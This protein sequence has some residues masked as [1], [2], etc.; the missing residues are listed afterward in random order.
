MVLLDLSTFLGRMHPL[1]VHLP[2]GFLLIAGIFHLASYF[3]KYDNL[4]KATEL[5]LLLGT[6]SGIA[7]CVLGWLLSHT[8]DYSYQLLENHKLSGIGLTALS[9]I[10]YIL[11]S[12]KGKSIIVVPKKA[13]SAAFLSIIVLMSYAGHQ[14]ANLTHGTEYLTLA[15][16]TETKREI[17]EK[18]EDVLV[19]EDLVQPI[20]DKKCTQCHQ[21]SKRKGELVLSSYDDIMKGGK[22][23]SIL[24]LGKI[25]E[26]E[27]IRRVTLER[28]HED[29]MPSDGKT[30]L[31]KNELAI[32]KWWITNDVVNKDVSFLSL[33]SH[34]EVL[35]N[36]EVYLG[37][38]KATSGN[39]ANM[40]TYNPN[41]PVISDIKLL[42]EIE[43][44]GFTYRIMNH[45]PLMLDIAIDRN[46]L[47]PKIEVKALLPL[48]KHIIWLNLSNAAVTD[49]DLEEIGQFENLEK[50]KLNGNEIDDGFVQKLASLKYLNAV[51]LNNSPVSNKGLILFKGHQNMK[52]IYVWQSQVTKEAVTVFTEENPHIKV[53]I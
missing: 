15:T 48:A 36:V 53:V 25:D 8:G 17:P 38:K 27:I 43:K 20:L 44:G 18:I 52:H 32:L 6:L 10:L 21:S 2:I 11:I 16:L 30:P 14:G 26:S 4:G 50:V 37:Y 24:I 45:E 5:A 9:L 46:R 1:V 31:T 29:F 35:E 19:F 42:K 51:N 12:D 28:E 7:A 22:N 33:K 49:A 3:P 23:G 47:K 40:E 13:L 39:L 34:T 41:I